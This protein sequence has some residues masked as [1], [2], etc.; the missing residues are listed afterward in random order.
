MALPQF[1]RHSTI[2]NYHDIN[3]VEMEITNESISDFST[4]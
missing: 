2:S 4:Q 3:F 1:S